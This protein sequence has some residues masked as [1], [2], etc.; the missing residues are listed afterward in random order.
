MIHELA[1]QTLINLFR[2]QNENVEEI[3]L[4]DLLSLISVLYKSLK[5]LA[6]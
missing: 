3:D 6:R 2:Y 1:L 5:P 4:M